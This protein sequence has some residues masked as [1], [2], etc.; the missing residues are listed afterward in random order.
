[1]IGALLA[2]AFAAAPAGVS[3]GS[4]VNVGAADAE[5]VL[6]Q[7]DA[8]LRAAGFEPRRVGGGCK[9]D[10]A[11]VAKQ[12]ERERLAVIVTAA[13]AGSKR[14][15]AIDLESISSGGAAVAQLTEQFGSASD[16]RLPEAFA[17]YARTMAAALLPKD[18]PVQARIEPAATPEPPPAP[19]ATIEELEDHGP[20]R[21]LV[22]SAA[23][24]SVAAGAGAAALAV[25]G[26][27][28]KSDAERVDGGRSPHTEVEAQRLVGDANARLTASL[29]CGLT[30]G[31]F[32]LAAAGLGI[33]RF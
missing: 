13:V 2:T 5:A 33:A 12:A 20:P 27:Q 19:L 16:L 26:F 1:M 6:V 7:L 8:A 30:A 23:G 9:G 14:G 21:W 15:L 25:Q 22:I 11:C 28:L 29:V 32:A 17:A 3:L 18:A 4:A 24:A 31:A 10:R